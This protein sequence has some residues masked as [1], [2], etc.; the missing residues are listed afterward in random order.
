MHSQS[1]LSTEEL[2]AMVTPSCWF[3]RWHLPILISLLVSIPVSLLVMAFH[4]ESL[5][6]YGLLTGV[7]CLLVFV[8]RLEFYDA[9]LSTSNV[10][11]LQ[12]HSQAYPV[13]EFMLSTASGQ[14]LRASAVRRALIQKSC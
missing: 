12:A 2:L 1:E 8:V 11:I 5:G 9:R 4:S 7:F 6:V 14:K 3:T 13:L 10:Q